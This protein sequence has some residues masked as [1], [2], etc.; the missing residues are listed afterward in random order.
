MKTKEFILIT[1]MLITLPFLLFAQQEFTGFNL[2]RKLVLNDDSETKE[3]KIDVSQKHKG[4]LIQVSSTI[5]S[6]DLI[7]EIYDPNKEKKGNFSVGTQ[8]SISK[9]IKIDQETKTKELPEVVN[10]QIRRGDENP[11]IGIWIVK[12]IPQ[13]AYGTV[14]IESNQ[15][16]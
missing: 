9:K 13:K 7:V 5:V 4:L 1:V 2:H 10:G 15:K 6:G 8:T 16:L 3:I 12:I 14:T 11:T